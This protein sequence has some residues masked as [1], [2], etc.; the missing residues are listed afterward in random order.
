LQ[1]LPSLHA[2]PFGR[3]VCWHPLA[4]LQESVVQALPSPQS[5]A[6][7]GAHVVP[8]QVSAPLQ[9][10][11]SLH[12]VPFG[13]VVCWQ[14]RTGWQVSVVQGFTS[15]QFGGTHAIVVDVVELVLVEELEEVEEVLVEE[16]VEVEL[17]VVEVDE[18]V[19]ML[20]DEDEVLVEV[21]LVEVDEVV[22]VVL[23]EELVDEEEVLEVDD[24]ELLE[25]VVA[26]TVVVEL[27]LVEVVVETVLEEELVDEEEVLEELV[28]DVLVVVLGAVAVMSTSSTCTCSS[29]AD[30]RVMNLI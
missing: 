22:E 12:P 28:D 7:P 14:P 18:V 29:V 1:A 15:S 16:E 21:V 25:E 10:F 19:E 11:P 9:A 23:V 5:R 6:M 17:V 13:T 2:V 8:W 24:E 26:V 4:G 3:V 20:V 27:V 30:S